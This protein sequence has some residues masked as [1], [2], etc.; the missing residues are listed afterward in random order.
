MKIRAAPRMADVARLAGVHGST[1]S[2]ALR[3]HPSIPETTR[4]RVRR[5][6]AQVGYQ[7]HPLVSAL[8]SF[9]R[10]A[11]E[12][13]RHTTLAFVTSSQPTDAWR[14]SRTLRDQLAGAQERAQ[15]LGYHIEEFP[16]HAPGL[17]PVRFNQMLRN[18]GIIGLIIA[19]LRNE[20]DTLPIQW[21]HFAAVA[22]AFTLHRPDIPR[23]GSDH[24]QSIRLAIAQCRRR[25]YRRI[26]LAVQRS[27]MER[28]ERQ[29]LAGYLVE[30]A[31]NSHRSMLEPLVADTWSESTFLKW[32]KAQRPNV[33]LTGGDYTSVLSWLKRVG[34]DVPGKVGVASLDLHVRDGSVAGIDQHSEELGAAVVDHLIARLHRNERGAP[35]RAVRLHVMGEWRE[36][37]TIRPPPATAR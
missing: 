10:S 35:P 30:H 29:W 28:V 12:I 32:F 26:G 27:I 3:N 6:A 7:T 4:D 22:I 5:A 8:M 14:E 1:V 33:I 15:L 19:P 17:S 2:L 16:L 31:E 25:G 36:G 18:R 20:H 23:V 24:G 21:E 34:V 11:R 37:V 13:P 9:R